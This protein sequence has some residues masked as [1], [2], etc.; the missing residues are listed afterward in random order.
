MCA[1]YLWVETSSLCTHI[2]NCFK[3]KRNFL[4]ARVYMGGKYLSYETWCKHHIW[5]PEAAKLKSCWWIFKLQVSTVCLSFDIS[6]TKITKLRIEIGRFYSLN[7]DSFFQSATSTKNFEQDFLLLQSVF[8][9]H[10]VP[11]SSEHVFLSF[12]LCYSITLQYVV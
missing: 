11:L 2:H 9:K 7:H 6:T 12:W 4:Y 8:K 5:W 10:H 3:S 1:L